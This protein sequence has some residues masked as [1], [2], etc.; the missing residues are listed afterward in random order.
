VSYDE[1]LRA[2]RFHTVTRRA[3]RDGTLAD[4][5]LIVV[6]VIE[7]SEATGYLVIYHDISELQRQKQY[8]QSL[9]EVSPT[10]IVTIDPDHKVTSWNPAAE[11]SSA[12]AA[13]RPSDRTSIHWWPTARR[14]TTKPCS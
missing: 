14:S 11:S 8:Y 4:V 5:E 3:R 6:P 1:A 12:I 2:G 7:G 9:L 13:R 10:A